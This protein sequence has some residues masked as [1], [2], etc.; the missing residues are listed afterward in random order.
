MNQAVPGFRNVA[1]T[2]RCEV[3]VKYYAEEDALIIIMNRR[4][5]SGGT[6]RDDFGVILDFEDEGSQNVTRID[7]LDVSRF[8]PLRTERGYDADTD[9]LTLGDK[10]TADYRVVDNGDFVSYRQWFD[11]GSEWDVVAV[12]LRRASVHLAPVLAA[13][14]QAASVGSV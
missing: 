4:G 6:L 3:K 5:R 13:L 2:W 7:I 9:T 10:P 12:D 14:P 11:D 8:L 1:E